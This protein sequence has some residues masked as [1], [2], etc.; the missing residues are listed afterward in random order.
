MFAAITY[1]WQLFALVIVLA[2]CDH[3]LSTKRYLNITEVCGVSSGPWG[4]LELDTSQVPSASVIRTEEKDIY[5]DPVTTI[6]L[7]ANRPVKLFLAP[8]TQP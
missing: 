2:G 7:M 3:N 4:P 5:G 6:R 1:R 8:A